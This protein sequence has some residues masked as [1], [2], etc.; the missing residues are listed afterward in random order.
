MILSFDRRRYL[1]VIFPT[2][3]REPI[4]L[5]TLADWIH[6]NGSLR[7]TGKRMAHPAHTRPSL[8]CLETRELLSGFAG[9]WFMNGNQPCVITQ[10]GST[11]TVTNEHGQ[12]ATAVTVNATQIDVPA[13]GTLMGT[14]SQN[15]AL[16]H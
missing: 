11:Y 2:K 7:K 13:W 15:G 9:E 12:S 10:Q 14:L 6:G 3:C 1:S 8:E 5:R 4:M 16:D